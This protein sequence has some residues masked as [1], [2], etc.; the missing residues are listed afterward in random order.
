MITSFAQLDPNGFYT[1]ADYLL[2]KFDE[3][4]ELLRGRVAQMSAPSRRHQGISSNLH[5]ILSNALWKTPCKVYA[6]PFDVRL[7]KSQN[8]EVTTVVQPDICV[9]C[10]PTKLDD[11]GCLG[12]PDLIIEIISPGNSKREMKDKFEIYQDAGVLEYW[13]VSPIEKTVQAWV[14]N[15]EKKYIGLQPLVEDDV[16]STAIIPGLVIDMKEVFLD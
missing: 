8:K 9:I 13:I 2:W 5:R 15:E 11:R 14:L 10:D 7:F 16:F 12:A 4:V 3:R 1:Y 6:A